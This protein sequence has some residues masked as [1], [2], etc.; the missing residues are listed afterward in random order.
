LGNR[1][2]SKTVGTEK[3]TSGPNA[4]KAHPPIEVKD[5]SERSASYLGVEDSEQ[6]GTIKAL[7]QR[8][9][10]IRGGKGAF[11]RMLFLWANK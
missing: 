6:G 3:K 2:S 9:A 11:R 4:N 10:E 7:V 5:L 1:Q 8:F